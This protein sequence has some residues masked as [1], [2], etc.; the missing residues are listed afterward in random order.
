MEGGSRIS[1]SHLAS[2]LPSRVYRSCHPLSPWALRVRLGFHSTGFRQ[3][4]EVPRCRP[5]HSE[6]G[7]KL[8]VRMDTRH[9]T[10]LPN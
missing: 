3:L 7:G 8:H 1:I 6:P 5:V 9:H 2:L 4:L 10:T